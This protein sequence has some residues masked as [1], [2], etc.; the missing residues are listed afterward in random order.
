MKKTFI[1]YLIMTGRYAILIFSII[2]TSSSL[3]T[4]KSSSGQELDPQKV[5][6][7]LRID[8]QPLA[9]VFKDIERQTH[10]R[11]FYNANSFDAQQPVSLRATRQS[12]E[13]I[14][15]ELATQTG[16]E[17]KQIDRYFSVRPKRTSRNQLQPLTGQGAGYGI[18]HIETYR[19]LSN[20][21]EDTAVHGRV[22]NEKGEPLPGVTVQIQGT[23]KGTV[24]TADGSFSLTAPEHAT[25][26]F[27]YVGYDPKQVSLPL[28]STAPIILSPNASGLN[29]VVVVGYGT[30]KR[31]DL[32]G[33]ISSIKGDDIKLLP[34]QRVDQALQGKAAG[35]MVLNTDGAPG[36]NTTIRIRGM[37]S[38]QG[39]NNA[40]VVIDGLQG[41]NL[42]SLN[43]DDIASI[44]VL[45]DA[46]ATAIYG[47]RGANGVILITTK[48]GTTGKPLISYN[49]DISFSSLSHKLPLLS[50]GDYARNINAVQLAN[51]GNGINPKPIFTDAQIAA[52]D[53]DGGTDWQDVIYRTGI[54]QNHQLS[55][56]GASDR[57][58]YRVSGEY[59][60]QEGILLN[61][62]YKRF[63]LRANLKTEITDWA[64]FGIHW[65]GTKEE[66][67]SAL[68]GGTTDWPNNPIGAATRFSPT[69]PVY[70]SAGNYNRAAN[71]YGNPTLWN[72]LASTL[73]PDIQ[74]GTIRN[75]VN[76][77]LDFKILE[78]LT[79]HISGGA[80]ITNINNTSFY[81]TKT[82]TGLQL[83]G[84]GV[85]YND[86][87]AYYQNSNQLTYDRTFGA[88]HLTVTAVAEQEFEK[89]NESTINSSDFTSQQTG[90][91]DLEGA[92]ITTTESYSSQRVIN[93]YLGRVNYIFANK[94]LVTASFR[95][96]GSSVFGKN[97]K[98]GY[99]PSTAIAWRA[100]EETFI[101]NLNLFSNLKIRGSW[102]I[103]GNQ[104]ISPYGTLARISSGGNYPYNGSDG[105]DIGFYISSAANPSL[106]WESTEQID[107]GLDMGFLN[108]RLTITADYYHKK[109]TDLLM[110][111]EL[112][113][114]TG[115]SSIIDNVGSMGNKGFELAIGGDPFVG[116]FSW[117]TDFNISANR[118]TVLNIGDQDKI[119]FKSGGSGQGTNLPFMYLVPGQPFGQM[120]GWGYE[121]TWKESEAHEAAQYGQ[122]PGDPHYTD[123]DHNG[124]INLDD[125]MVIGNSMPKFIFGW[126]NRLS[127]KN[128]SLA[129]QVQGKQGNDIFNVAR[130][131]LDASDGTSI[132]LKDRWTPDHQNATIPAIIDQRT[133]E[134]AHLISTVSF[135]SS[136]GN[137][138][139]R[140]VEDGSYIRLKNVTLSYVIP[141]PFTDKIG[142]KE[143]M[144]HASVTNVLTIT[145]YTGYDPEVSSF[146]SNDAQ[147][148][149]D[150][151]NYPQSRIF[152]IGVNVSF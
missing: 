37:N 83:N 33:S 102:G 24:T 64:T 5:F 105:T 68:F 44:E 84:S 25:L 78:G 132:R 57:V 43:P 135:P 113:T 52:F 61:S 97:N 19:T 79:L 7:T 34:T 87:S 77:Y 69:I 26:V 51:N 137:T 107:I 73:E 67:N 150:Y 85:T 119:G 12:L 109:T 92:N 20:L 125:Q 42:N 114:F 28:R 89:D 38:I 72:P 122:L 55:I 111:R 54:T 1:H 66:S 131:A 39:G 149:A 71:D 16:L 81:N 98:W 58:S 45:K 120:I 123:K 63:S 13:M 22:Q 103:T 46:S 75:N 41:G 139:S 134:N 74:N 9:T 146:N 121:G 76:A 48:T 136:A 59:L 99:F 17:F 18:T 21:P 147:I 151:N 32:T 53:E 94:Y 145:H 6:L 2:V 142:L 60:D 124:M 56:G 35:M 50:A 118:T 82:F 91:H 138:L 10:F 143:V 23:T 47:S 86:K 144:L 140:Y 128:F 110:P 106:K 129:F 104:A 112:P 62:G 127:Y 40:L 31:S 101:R 3:L 108:D 141:K 65:A 70:D 14:L 116:N 130:I 29:E 133:R 30:Q 49:Y 36:G 93:S 115:L 148:G 80:V 100:S 126:N 8:Q 4:A 11:F 152:D 96:D 27:S 117:H 95:A 15:Q 90:I 88:H